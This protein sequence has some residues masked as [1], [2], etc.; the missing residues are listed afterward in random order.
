MAN[1]KLNIGAGDEPPPWDEPETEESSRAPREAEAR[2]A[3]ERTQDWA[4]PNLLPDPVK[5][6][7]WEYRYIRTSFGGQSDA[8]NVNYRFRE[9]WIPVTIN[10]QPHLSDGI[11]QEARGSENIVIGGLML[12]KMPTK[13]AQQRRAAMDK[14]AT[15]QILGVD[16]DLMRAQDPRMPTITRNYQSK[17]EYGPKRK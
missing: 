14:M 13:M 12:C 7:G 4:Q 16:N 5:M 6:P 8:R 2:T 10:E 17:V 3:E 11:D 9:G 1:R 15:D